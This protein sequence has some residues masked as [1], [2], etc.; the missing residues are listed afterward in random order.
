MRS[1]QAHGRLFNHFDDRNACDMEAG[2]NLQFQFL[3]SS[4]DEYH[5][6][7][8]SISPMMTS[9]LTRRS[10]HKRE[11]PRLSNQIQLAD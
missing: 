4:Q 10:Q 5:Q 8:I 9:I 3:S 7:V 11:S 2:E 6:E 1:E